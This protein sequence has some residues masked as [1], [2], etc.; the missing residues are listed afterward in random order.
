[1]KEMV[2]RWEYGI[3]RDEVLMLDTEFKHVLVSL[4]GVPLINMEIVARP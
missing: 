4:V 3:A 1:M 2:R